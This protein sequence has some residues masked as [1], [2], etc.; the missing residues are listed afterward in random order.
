MNASIF[1]YTSIVARS[2]SG[3]LSVIEISEYMYDKTHYLPGGGLGGC[4]Q[5]KG[6]LISPIK[7]GAYMY[8]WANKSKQATCPVTKFTDI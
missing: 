4:H 7:D 1:W 3:S 8:K 2:I 6:Q 5:S